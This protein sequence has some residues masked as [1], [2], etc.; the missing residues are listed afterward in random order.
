MTPTWSLHVAYMQP[1]WC[2]PVT[3][4]TLTERLHDVYME[5]A[6]SRHSYMERTW[7]LQNAYI[8][9]TLRLN[10]ACM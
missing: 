7:S 9:L 5:P 1:T 10:E 8:P 4:R 6:W 2:L 3:R